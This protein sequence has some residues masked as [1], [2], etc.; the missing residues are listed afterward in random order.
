M[1]PYFLEVAEGAQA[2]LPALPGTGALAVPLDRAWSSAD[3]RKS[4]TSPALVRL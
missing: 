2:C 3:E 1:K 4:P